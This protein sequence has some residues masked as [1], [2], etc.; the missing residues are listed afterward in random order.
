M[1]LVPCKSSCIGFIWVPFCNICDRFLHGEPVIS[2][3]AAV[4]DFLV[5]SCVS[6]AGM[7]DDFVAAAVPISYDV[8]V[9]G[10]YLCDVLS[11]QY[12]Y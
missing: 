10:L 8:L 9:G 7:L 5:I 12:F 2:W 3:A 4:Q 6:I 11:S 1:L